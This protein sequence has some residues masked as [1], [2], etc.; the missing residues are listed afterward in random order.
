MKNLTNEQQMQILDECVKE[1][2]CTALVRQY[3][4]LV[5]HTVIRVY[6]HKGIAFT[7]ADVEDRVQDVFE[8]LFKHNKYKLRQ[9]DPKHGLKLD[10]WIR[11][12]AT[13][14]VLDSFKG[15]QGGAK[16]NEGLHIP[17][18]DLEMMTGGR[19][20]GTDAETRCIVSD[21][22]NRLGADEKLVLKLEYQKGLSPKKIG[23][24]MGKTANHIYQI[25]KRALENL[26]KILS[27]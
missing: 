22:I 1:N 14:T 12:I 5:R 3:L 11:L 7:S 16:K 2:E 15:R 4:L 18:E 25:K 8:V 27:L 23:Q 13:Q 24:S 6:R 20:E 9:Y 21:A 10:G 19:Y 17:L 26:R